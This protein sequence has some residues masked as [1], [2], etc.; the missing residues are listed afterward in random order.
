MGSMGGAIIRRRP[1]DAGGE[2]P[3]MATPAADQAERRV[4]QGGP[5]MTPNILV[6]RS[7]AWP[8]FTDLVASETTRLRAELY[9]RGTA[10]G[11]LSRWVDLLSSQA[12]DLVPVE[13]ITSESESIAAMFV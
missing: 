10:A 2:L 7:E 5:S 11:I 4:T 6:T 8:G 13:T 9:E 12:A 3:A 1:D